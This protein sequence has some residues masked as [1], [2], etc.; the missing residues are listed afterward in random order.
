MSTRLKISVFCLV[1]ICFLLPLSL[2]GQRGKIIRPATPTPTSLAMD[3]NQDRFVSATTSGFST[4]GDYVGEFEITMFG[5][6]QVGGD[7]AG[8]NTGNSCGITD[9]IPDFKGR[10]TYAVLDGNN[11]IFRFRVGDDNPSVESWTILLDSDGL[12]GAADPN[13]TPDNPGFEIDITLIKRNN[14]G[15][16]VYNINGIDNCP[17]PLLSYP[18]STNFQISI[19][20]E[21]TCGDPDYF[22]DFFVPFNQLASAFGITSATGL[23]FV[24][25]SNVSAT[26]AMAGQIADVSGVD[27]NLPE[28]SSCVTC[29]FLDLVENQCPTPI[30]DLCQTC[31]GFEK[32][33]VNAPTID[34]PV[35]AGQTIISGTSDPGIYIIVEIYSRTGGTDAVPIWSTTPREIKSNTAIGINWAV[36]LSVPLQSY[37]KII[38]KAQKNAAS[39]PCG[40]NG[41]NQ[42]S[43]SVTVVQP[44]TPPVAQSQT[45]L[46]TEDVPINIV[47]TGT[48]PESNL[49]IYTI[50]TP[51]L[52][53]VL[54]GTGPGTIYTPTSNYNGP[55]SFTFQVSD[56]IFSSV[57]P[58]TVSITVAPLNDAPLANSQSVTILEDAA[59]V[60]TLT[61]G[62]VDGDVLNYSIVS[63]PLHG[64]LSGS[65]ATVTY[66]PVTNYNGFDSFTFKVNDGITDSNIATVS[67]TLTAVA[68]GPIAT[69]QSITTLEDVSKAIT[70]VGIDPDGDAIIYL[71]VS[72]PLHGTL[73]GSGANFTFIPTGNYNGPDSFTFKVNDG[74]T[75]SNIATVSITITP[76]ND[77]PIANNQ[78]VST[79]EGNAKLIT[80]TGSDVDGNPLAFTVTSAPLH[81]ALSGIAPNLTYTPTGNYNGPDNFTFKVNDGFVDS[82]IATVSIS[83]TPVN[84]APIANNQNITTPEDVALAITLSGNDAEGSALT[85]SIVSP[86]TNGFLSG[87]A[88]N[89][90]YTPVLNYNGSDNFTFKVN[91]GTVDSSPATVTIDV[92]PVND[93]PIAN[94][95]SANYNLNTPKGITLTGSD[96][97]GTSLTFLVLTFP[98]NGTLT[99]TAPNLTYTPNTGYSGAETF[100][101]HVSDGVATSAIA[102]VSLSLTPGSNLP[103]V[104]FNQTRSIAEEVPTLIILNATDANGDALT[105]SITTP[106]HGLL[107][108]SGP[109]VTYT[110]DV[111][112]NGPDSFTFTVNDGLLNSNTATVSITVTPVND[113]PTSDNQSVSTPE[114]IAIGITLTGSDVDGDALGYSIG[115]TP[116]HGT[117]SGSPPSVI[118]TPTA[119]FNGIDN[120]T[121]ET[122]DGIV[123]SNFAT[124]SILVTA[125]NNSPV[126]NPQNV[127]LQEDVSQGITLTASDIDL[128]ALSYIIVS[129]PSHGVLSGIAPNLTYT[130]VQNYNGLDNFT[131]KVND[132]S[133]DSSP[134]TV[135]ISISPVN[136]PPTTD[137]QSVT[138]SED[139]A[140]VIIL[141]GS[142]LDSDI[143]I[144]SILSSPS[145]GTL[146]GTGASITY[147][148]LSNYN[149]FDSFTFKINDGTT[150]SNVGTVS[151]T[152]TPVS[153]PPVAFDLG[154]TLITTLEDLPKVITLV[155]TDPDGDALT[156]IIVT[157][158]SHGSISG[159]GPSDISFAV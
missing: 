37:D 114:N 35:R 11:L 76:I 74:T 119:N 67:I 58:G 7:V 4:D 86:P 16:Y 135:S 125:V 59:T 142:D 56:G 157:P 130:P 92:T 69:N 89:V 155:G 49:L 153:D 77:S 62:D 148:P 23:R 118:Y 18:I 124:V 17:S 13:S 115:T 113:T 107:N 71:L 8:D 3:P 109:N 87:S 93:P 111:N 14:A 140:T 15:V 70:L 25:V 5:I 122:N 34:V 81:G 52:H 1:S 44:N 88:P 101:F 12:F 145:H 146:T 73:S 147:T 105:Y 90:T 22:Y 26:C 96:P 54:N 42:A 40:V 158:P 108:V 82:N 19:A 131:F 100:T 98:T 137:N 94:S 31:G 116:S 29:A 144:Y 30:D 156:Y 149:G 83:I 79:P 57:L 53:G 120:F 143:L 43:A 68:D 112:Y 126:A 97:E 152:V 38:A 63:G 127:T 80:L 36:T 110:S 99:G 45:V 51:P 136:D 139:L 121:F 32:D 60:I 21:V 47:L 24:A 138:T 117:L 150:D 128:D 55:D 61:A 2:L 66:T 41:A 151:L 64:A 20:D 65:G 123:N 103:P 46:A 84:D 102:T 33:K 10:S 28:Y 104:A 132:G 129:S 141:T 78:S 6:P 27:N 159:T 48:D 133:V 154:G 75:D 106:T 85:Y 95:Q 39:V 9:L 72:S 50:V 134:A 91:D